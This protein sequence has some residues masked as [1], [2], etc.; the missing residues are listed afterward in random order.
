MQDIIESAIPAPSNPKEPPVKIAPLKNTSDTMGQSS[1]QAAPH[2]LLKHPDSV[3]L[4]GQ[5]EPSIRWLI[6]MLTEDAVMETIA[7]KSSTG[8]VAAKNTTTDVHAFRH[9]SSPSASTGVEWRRGAEEGA[10]KARRLQNT[11]AAGRSRKRKLEYQRVL[12]ETIK[13][14]LMDEK[15]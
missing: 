11:V 8:A 5:D 13:A 14:E 15:M 3:A 4:A 9:A 7:S 12:E 1:K 10:I 6:D 2:S